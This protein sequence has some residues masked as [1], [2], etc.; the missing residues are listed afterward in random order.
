[1]R[2][3]VL[4]LCLLTSVAAFAQQQ[5]PARYRLERIVVE[6][7]NISE[8]VVRAEARLTEE[9]MYTEEDFRQA[10]YRIRRLPFVTDA[11]YRIEPGVTAGGTTLI[12]RILGTTALF[13]DVDLR[14]DRTPDGETH[15]DAAVLI[16]GRALLDNLGVFE[17]AVRKTD[18][19]D[20]LD[21][22]IAYRAYG[23]MGTG[24]FG[25]IAIGKRIRAKELD[26][27]PSLV[28]TL[29]YP[30]S[31]KQTISLSASQ[32]KTT[33]K[34][35][36]DVNGDDDDNEDTDSDKDDNV[37]LKDRNK[38]N[39]AEL[40]WSYESTDDVFFATRGISAG[41]GPNWSQQTA[42]LDH[43]D[44]T[45]KKVVGTEFEVVRYGFAIDAAGYRTLFGRNVAF[46][47]LNGN[48]LREDESEIETVNG[49]AF[50]GFAHD[51]HSYAANTLRPFKAR[52]ELGAGYRTVRTRF[53]DI[54]TV[55]HNDTF[56]EAG[57]VMRHRWGT[58]RLTGTYEN[59]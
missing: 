26:Y 20:G 51:F 42:V 48:G 31:Q 17:G 56:A 4:S 19:G 21:L 11:T 14:G 29:G 53:P 54:D 18:N 40:R 9:R 7:S 12:V 22:G 36:F 3:I 32:S 55:S 10:V 8:D 15:K 49:Q 45:E 6:G 47:T 2:S 23:I 25:S 33:F 38:F 16:G 58:I 50:L 1:M 24:G 52:F 34:R 30:L 28:L 13:Y 41:A 46:L 39:Y 43:Y 5:Q 37:T 27:A 44:T 59:E 35:D 57:F